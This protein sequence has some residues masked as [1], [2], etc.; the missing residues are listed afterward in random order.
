MVVR[1]LVTRIRFLLD[2]TSITKAENSTA[3]IKKGLSEAGNSGEQAGKKISKGMRESAKAANEAKKAIAASSYTAKAAVSSFR[4]GKGLTFTSTS[5]TISAMADLGASG[6]KAGARIS[7]GMKTAS[8]AVSEYS[9]VVN[10]KANIVPWQ[11]TFKG[12]SLSITGLGSAQSKISGLNASIAKAGFSLKE[13]SPIGHL[14]TGVYMGVGQAIMGV[15]TNAINSTIEAGTRLQQ[16]DGRLRSVTKS[17][18]ERRALEDKLFAV[19]DNSRSDIDSVGDLYYKVARSSDQTGLNEQQ[20][21]DLTETVGKALTVGG[22]STQEKSAT[23]L[24]LSQALGSGVLQGDELRSL[25]DNASGLMNEMAKYFNTT[26]GG[27]KELGRQ[28]ELTSKEVAKAI[29]FAKKNIDEQYE[30]MPMTISDAMTKIKNSIKKGLLEVEAN[31]GVLSKIAMGI[32]KP[33]QLLQRGFST[34]STKVGGSANLIRIMTIALGSLGAAIAYINFSKIVSGIQT[35]VTA[36][37]AFAVANGFAMG[38]VMLIAA[39]IALVALVLEDLYT[40]INGG[41]SIT[42]DLLGSFEDLKKANPWIEG[43]ITS[44]KELGTILSNN[45]EQIKEGISGIDFSAVMPALTALGQAILPV[46]SAAF[47]FIGAVVTGVIQL[48]VWLITQFFEF[49]NSGNIVAETIK[50]IFQTMVDYIVDLI[51][52]WTKVFEGDWEGAIEAGKNAF[53]N[54][55]SHV[56]SILKR[57]AGAIGQY[58]TNKLAEAKNAVLGFLGWSNEQT[59][60]AIQGSSNASVTISQNISGATVT[61]TEVDAYGYDISL[62]DM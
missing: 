30:K 56:L 47:S 28:G 10:R 57:I 40:W 36:I 13:L 14:V 42:G 58:V 51:K 25:N 52:F 49:M 37:Q 59:S 54:L 61:T 12:K 21:L 11:G 55:L 9:N 24:Q 46:I 60:N 16:L 27:L 26:V 33:F 4:S 45:W 62:A 34:L 8:K 7:E 32:Y 48:V 43:L 20:N 39:A 50:E 6:T 15:M 17:D 3:E 23:I 53:S 38:Q 1:E 19:A 22:A 5:K 18:A 35:I 2:K 41:E 44:F 29:L 31:T